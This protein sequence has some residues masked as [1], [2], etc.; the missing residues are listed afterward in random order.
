MTPP[1]LVGAAEAMAMPA[2][3]AWMS[4]AGFG[5]GGSS[6][7]CRW[8]GVQ[9]EMPP[10]ERSAQ[11]SCWRPEPSRP[12]GWGETLRLAGIQLGDGGIRSLGET[13][14]GLVV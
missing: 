9:S 10:A 13:G 12:R 7:G 1:F 5:V 3:E 11:D 8:L 2:T 6:L 4:G 14:T